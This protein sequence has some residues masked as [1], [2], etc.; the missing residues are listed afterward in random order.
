MR[1]AW[2]YMICGELEQ[3]NLLGYRD[4]L[5]LTDCRPTAWS[6]LRWNVRQSVPMLTGAVRV[7]HG[8]ARPPTPW[9][10]ITNA[11]S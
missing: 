9:G 10:G 3:M 6:A 7:A 8:H 5:A 4:A 2:P 1:I 11:R